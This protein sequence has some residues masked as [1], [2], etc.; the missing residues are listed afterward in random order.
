VAQALVDKVL[1]VALV[2][3]TTLMTNAQEEVVAHLP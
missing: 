1:L 2:D 3:G